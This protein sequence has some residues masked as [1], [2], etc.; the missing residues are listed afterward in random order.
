MNNV[1]K[2][3]NGILLIGTII[4]IGIALKYSAIPV[5]AFFPAG[6]SKFWVTSAEEQQMFMLLYDIALG[7]LMSELFYFTVEEIPTHYRIHKSKQ[8]IYRPVNDVL[9][10]MEQLISIVTQ[11]YDIDWNG[12]KLKEQNFEILNRNC[13]Y[14]N[15]KI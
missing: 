2:I 14:A 9:E 15:K 1:R 6:F 13:R 10:N 3:I 11:L 5:P 7:F 12:G 8:M 4:S